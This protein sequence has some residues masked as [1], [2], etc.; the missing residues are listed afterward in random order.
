MGTSRMKKKEARH[1][2]RLVVPME[3]APTLRISRY[4]VIFFLTQGSFV[5]ILACNLTRYWICS[6]YCCHTYNLNILGTRIKALVS[7][8]WNWGVTWKLQNLMEFNMWDPN[9]T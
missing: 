9:Y 4:S 3:A 5:K 2:S 7:S 6:P 8:S 1:A